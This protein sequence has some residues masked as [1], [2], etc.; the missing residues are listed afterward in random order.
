LLPVFL[1]GY[2]IYLPGFGR[3]RGRTT[4]A[5]VFSNANKGEG[6]LLIV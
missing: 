2:G 1:L 6:E 3:W 4:P 5:Y